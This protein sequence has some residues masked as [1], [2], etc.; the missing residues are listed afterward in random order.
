MSEAVVTFQSQ[1][2]GVME[3]VFKAAMYEITRLVEDSFLEEVTRSREKVE[4]LKRRL[5][6]SESRRKERD[7]DG[8]RENLD[9]MPKEE[10]LSITP[11]PDDT[12][13]TERWGLNLNGAEGAG[14]T[15]PSKNIK[16]PSGANIELSGGFSCLLINEEGYL[17]DQSALY[18]EHGSGA[19]GRLGFK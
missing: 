15:S 8:G 18:P 16:S 3:T 4:S 7:R 9:H 19:S 5:K 13:L 2:S 17:Q 12:E 10:A 14:L 11:T 6:W 1:L